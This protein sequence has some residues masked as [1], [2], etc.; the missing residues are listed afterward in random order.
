MVPT[1][2]GYTLVGTT[3]PIIRRQDL[4]R[5]NPS[6]DV[7]YAVRALRERSIYPTWRFLYQLRHFLASFRQWNVLSWRR[8]PHPGPPSSLT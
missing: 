2:I 3:A 7:R 6:I 1:R 4:L 5:P 8:R